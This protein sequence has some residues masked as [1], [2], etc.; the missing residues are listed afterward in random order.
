MT[1]KAA[2]VIPILKR[3]PPTR[4]IRRCKISSFILLF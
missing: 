2:A 1:S 4:L 3:S